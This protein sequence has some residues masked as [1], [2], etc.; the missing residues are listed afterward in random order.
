MVETKK[1]WL[2]FVKNFALFGLALRIFF[3]GRCS[4]DWVDLGPAPGWPLEDFLGV[5][6]WD[7]CPKE[8]LEALLVDEELLS[9]LVNPTS[10]LM[11][12]FKS[13]PLKKSEINFWI[14]GILVDPL[15]RTMSWMA[16]L[17]ILASRRDFSTGLRVPLNKSEQGSSKRALKINKK[18]KFGNFNTIKLN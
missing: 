13:F 11:D 10:G 7:D 5:W 2:N 9:R 1:N 15:T 6:D 4:W 3:T 16:D 17:S 18:L 14:L 8:L 12:L